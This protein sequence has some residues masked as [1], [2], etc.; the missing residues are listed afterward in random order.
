MTRLLFPFLLLLLGGCSSKPL[1]PTEGVNTELTAQRVVDLERGVSGSR[2]LWGGVIVNITNLRERSRLEVLA[3]PLDSKQRPQTD[4]PAGRR[5][6]AYHPGYLESTDY[7]AGRQVSM[8]GTV[9]GIEEAPLGEHRY[10]YPVLNSER[11]HLWPVEPP[12][13]EPKVRFG[14]GVILHN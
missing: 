5:F 4:Q 14:I 9:G 10:R 2:V 3:Y 1:L 7:A 13:S 11:L 12:Q 8:V 6:F